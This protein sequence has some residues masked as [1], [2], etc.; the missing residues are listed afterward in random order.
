MQAD[1]IYF[2]LLFNDPKNRS[3]NFVIRTKLEERICQRNGK[4]S[5]S[6]GVTNY[7]QSNN[8]KCTRQWSDELLSDRCLTIDVT[9]LCH[10]EGR[11][12]SRYKNHR[13]KERL[14]H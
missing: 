3:S 12:D 2:V 4:L 13:S 11:K 8:W 1:P 10:Q 6:I 14:S 7:V 9:H 5:L